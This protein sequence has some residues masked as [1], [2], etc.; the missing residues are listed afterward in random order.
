MPSLCATTIVQPMTQLGC[1]PPSSQWRKPTDHPRYLI[2]RLPTI[3]S[4]QKYPLLQDL[5][6]TFPNPNYPPLQVLLKIE[7]NPT[8]T[9][10]QPYTIFVTESRNTK[11][12]PG[13]FYNG[14]RY[15]DN[16]YSASSNRTST[17]GCCVIQ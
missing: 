17:R 14:P 2:N 11:T 8:S 12:G 5:L 13:E 16:S 10:E 6:T 7:P 9:A 1:S 15:P 3:F 4:N